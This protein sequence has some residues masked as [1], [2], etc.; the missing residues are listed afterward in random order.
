MKT[1]LLLLLLCTISLFTCKK[2]ES[3]Q[4]LPGTSIT[5]GHSQLETDFFEPFSVRGTISLNKK[6]GGSSVFRLFDKIMERIDWN[7]K[8]VLRQELRYLD[9]NKKPTGTH[10]TYYD[11]KTLQVLHWEYR[12]KDGKTAFI[13]EQE[14]TVIRG[15]QK[16][17][18]PRDQWQSSDIG[19]KVFQNETRELF[20][21]ALQAN[22]GDV[23]KFP[24]I[25]NQPPFHGWV[26]YT[27]SETKATTYKGSSYNAKIWTA[28]TNPN[29]YY[30]IIDVPPYVIERGV[31]AGSEMHVFTYDGYK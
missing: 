15:T 11:P 18:T 31:Q 22:V 26:S 16:A 30:V 24:I 3:Q 12:L 13:F 20:F 29:N 14:N 5:P 27:Y 1:T 6:N 8:Q 21:R 7:D 9:S 28:T 23:I 17:K 2:A 4:I 25:G 19:T 10:I